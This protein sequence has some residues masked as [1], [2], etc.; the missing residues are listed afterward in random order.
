MP[1]CAALRLRRSPRPLRSVP[2][3][4]SDP[5]DPA[6][7]HR[8]VLLTEVMEYLDVTSA[9]RVL[10]CTLGLGGHTEAVLA[11]G[12]TVVGVDRDPQARALATNRLGAYGDRL[13]VI[14]GTYG[15]AA[16]ELAQAGEQ[17]DGVL[18]DIGISSLQV[19]DLERGFSLRSE[20]DL[21]LRMGAGCPETALELIDRLSFEDLAELIKRYGEEPRAR[22]AARSLKWARDQGRTSAK[23]L[24]DAVAYALGQA[25]RHPA[26]RT[27]QALRIAVN[28]ELGELRR[29]LEVL[30]ALLVPGGRA[31]VIS[32]HSLEDRLV[33]RAFRAYASDSRLAVVTTKPVIAGEDELAT[34]P[35][36][37]SAKLRVASRPLAA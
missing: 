9:T 22:R 29:L 26:V 35:R 25:K 12:G 33:K 28:N 36:A 6:A 24:A 2:D 1:F 21:D 16:A 8:P 10:D 15:Q 23:G 30:P 34:N 4:A 32:F 11:A 37:A 27:F 17:F 13:R 18:A 5:P 3:P 31:A 19:D 20:A 14:A 7:I